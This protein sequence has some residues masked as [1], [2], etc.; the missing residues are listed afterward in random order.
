[1]QESRKYHLGPVAKFRWS[2]WLGAPRAGLALW[3]Y[4][5]PPYERRINTIRQKGSA[6]C[7][8][9]TFEYWLFLFIPVDLAIG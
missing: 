1:M 6:W 4:P 8:L 7:V 3:N 5:T 9:P 2:A